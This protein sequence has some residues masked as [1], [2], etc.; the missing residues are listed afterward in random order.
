MR[1]AVTLTCFLVLVCEVYGRAT[2]GMFSEK[3]QL[4]LCNLFTVSVMI[5]SRA[6][7]VSGLPGRT[8]LAS[9]VP[10]GTSCS[11]NDT[12][13][14]GAQCIF[15]ATAGAPGMCTANATQA[16]TAKVQS[17][18]E[19]IVPAVTSVASLPSFTTTDAFTD[20]EQQKFVL[21]LQTNIRAKVYAI[22]NIK[23]DMVTAATA[24]I[25]VSN[26]ATF[27]DANNDAALAGQKALMDVYASD[28]LSG[29]FGTEYGNVTV[30]DVSNGTAANPTL[31]NGAGRDSVATCTLIAALMAV[32]TAAVL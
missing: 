18:T 6:A 13:V 27:T 10:A 29:I 12:C 24:S 3:P 23:I 22:V 25:M 1:T 15:G 16:S 2:V 30:S 7:G 19:K 5:T 31:A 28:D 21:N 8:L 26:T 14:A 32:I 4:P 11:M 20:D 17:S 9:N